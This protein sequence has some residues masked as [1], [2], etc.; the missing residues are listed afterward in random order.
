MKSEELYN[1]LVNN[2]NSILTPENYKHVINKN[3]NL[4]RYDILNRLLIEI[5]YPGAYDVRTEDEWVMDNRCIKSNA[6]KI[7][8]MCPVYKHQY[9]DTKTN[10]PIKDDDLSID[11]IS[12]AL[13]YGII[14]RDDS[15][16]DVSVISV[17]DIRETKNT[18]D[19]KYDILKLKL[20]YQILLYVATNI[21]RCSVVQSESNSYSKENKKLFVMKQDYNSM[22]A[23]VAKTLTEHYKDDLV[24]DAIKSYNPTIIDNMTEYDNELLIN[25]IQYTIETMFGLQS[26]ISF[27]IV[28]HTNS[29]RALD[30]LIIADSITSELNKYLVYNKDNDSTSTDMTYKIEIMK[31]A[32]MLL[33]IM[34]ANKINKIMKGA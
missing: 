31:R 1:I 26:E 32:E 23:F 27:D 18:V 9:I 33:D 12:L 8:I 25:T 22:A 21:L 16:N 19:D 5:Q 30:I 11:E 29:E 4:S 6:K 24:K 13:K 7:N 34:E 20:G 15:I 2:I 28:T 17:Y 10:E 14:R 3:N